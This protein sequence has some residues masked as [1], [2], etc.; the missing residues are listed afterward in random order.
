MD[1]SLPD[2]ARMI[3]ELAANFAAKELV[4]LERMVV[5][6]EANRGMGTDP[7]LPPEVEASLGRKSQ[8]LGLWGLDV[9]ERFGGHGLGAL[10]KCVVAEQLFYSITP[11]TLPP[12]SPNLSFLAECCKGEQI[13]RYLLPYSRGEKKSCLALSEAAA[14]SDAAG[15]RMKA[16]R[17]NGKWVLNGEK[18]WISG[19]RTAD[20]MIVVA[21]TDSALGT[22]GGMTAFLVDRGTPGLAVTSDFAMIGGPFHP[23]AVTFNDVQLEDEQVLG[24]L[25]NAFPPLQN[26]LGIRR[27]ETACWCVGYASRCIDLMIEQAK[28]RSTFGAPLAERQT[29]QWWIAD[30][31]QELEMVRLLTYRLAWQL[32]QHSGSSK[33]TE[34]RRGA[35]MVKVQ[36]TEMATRVIDR[37]VQLFGGMG[38]SKEMPLEYM[39]RTV[40]VLRI[41]EGPSEIHRWMI[42]RELLRDGRPA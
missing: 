2:E 17:R 37:A 38:L 8:E 28:N 1:F 5:E 27:M 21:V 15:I 32:D 20:F 14:G 39:L 34:I 18:M 41:V 33:R 22:R 29:I 25:G 30:S 16:V 31:Y 26:R 13:E 24:E 11:F 40:R 19:A 3:Q 42:A 36:A 4:P 23:C 12:D 10:V 35:A 9:P 6:R 7:I